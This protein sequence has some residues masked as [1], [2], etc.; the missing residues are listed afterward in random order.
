MTKSFF[1]S[2]KVN[3]DI[4]PAILVVLVSSKMMRRHYSYLLN[5]SAFIYS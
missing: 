1:H 2:I 4:S 3:A 5:L